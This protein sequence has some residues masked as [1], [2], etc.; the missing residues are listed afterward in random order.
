MPI[1]RRT[2][3]LGAATTAATS[4]A[5]VV[6]LDR[7]LHEEPVASGAVAP[8]AADRKLVVLFLDGGND[9]LNT[10]IP[11]GAAAGASR[12]AELRGGLAI[13]PATTHDIG[14]GF[15][16]HPS[17]SGAKALFDDGRLAVVHGVGFSSLDR[18]HF[19][20]RDVWQAGDEHDLSTGWI[21][22]WL[23]A[24]AT[25]PLDAVAVGNRLPLL[26][27]G[28][29]RSAAVVPAGPFV[30]PGDARLRAGVTAL[31]GGAGADLPPLA[32]AVASSTADLLEI[33][34]RIPAPAPPAAGGTATAGDD[35]GLTAKFEAVAR[36]I[37]AGL[38]T[39]VFAVSLGGFDTHATQAATHADLLAEV[40]AALATFLARV[41]SGVTVVVHSEF[42]RRVAANASDGTDHG[43]GGTMLVAG[44]VL[45]GH[46]GEPPS[47]DALV[48]GDLA[49]TV[50]FRSVYA[51]LLGD[52][53]GFEAKDVLAKTPVALSLV[54]G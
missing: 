39:R 6:A 16:L 20:C 47:L 15:G 26:A 43:A 32:A 4:A 7:L 12:Y 24:E 40:D 3:L 34:D 48:G 17:L 25:S 8:K 37:E 42:G 49:T 52:V 5:G 13:D 11:I 31:S 14:E 2:F 38:P 22:R 33:V 35:G 45:G 19:H 27:R 46:H 23:D 50:D 51:G 28:A 10:V 44:D 53:L 9:A 29:R 36:I 1:T 54:P 18:S 21:G 30:L 41:A